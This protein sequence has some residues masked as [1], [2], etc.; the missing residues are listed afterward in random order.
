MKK[1]LPLLALLALVLAACVPGVQKPQP[2]EARVEAFDLESLDPFTGEARFAL[3]LR[4][5]NPNAFELPLLESRLTLGF[6]RARLPFD[7]P[8]V[9]LPAAGFEIVDTRLVVPIA[10]TAEGVGKLL[11]GEPVRLRISGKLRAQVGPVPVDLGP[12]TLLDETVR[13]DLRFAAPRFAVDPAQSRLRIAGSSL[14]VVVGFQVT[15]PN[16][17]GFYVRGPVGLVIGGRVVAEAALDLPLRP[18][19]TGPGR[20]VF[21]VDLVQVPGAAAALVTGLPVEL[22]GGVRAEVPG[23]W[24]QLLDVVFGG[25]VR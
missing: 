22:H 12:F 15:N 3:R 14:E 16:P 4:V 25:R 18:R 1:P 8:A 2:P 7:L 9:T 13:L 21:R 19:Q 24:E 23:V 11:R 6:D 17:I 5:R 10:E 20:L